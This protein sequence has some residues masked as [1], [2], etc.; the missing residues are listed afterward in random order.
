M[1]PCRLSHIVVEQLPWFCRCF[2]ILVPLSLAPFCLLI[3]SCTNE[4]SW[5]TPWNLCAYPVAVCYFSIAVDQW[6]QLVVMLVCCYC[7]YTLL[8]SQDRFVTAVNEMNICRIWCWKWNVLERAFLALLLD[9]LGPLWTEMKVCMLPYCHNVLWVILCL[10][11]PIGFATK[12]RG[13]QFISSD[14][15]R[16]WHLCSIVSL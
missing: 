16:T 5:K 1:D 6:Y 2:G 14:F 4:K 3:L 8:H 15:K 10:W 11:I 13:Q 9:T 7:C 12:T